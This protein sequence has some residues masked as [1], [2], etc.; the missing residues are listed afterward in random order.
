MIYR[1]MPPAEAL[2]TGQRIIRCLLT[3]STLQSTDDQ[4][5]ELNYS[6]LYTISI[7]QHTLTKIQ[8][9]DMLLQQASSDA[10]S[11]HVKQRNRRMHASLSVQR[12]P[13]AV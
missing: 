9:R 3:D 1:A 10:A 2:P 4:R 11:G 12:M 6:C 7:G 5:T 8:D 13:A